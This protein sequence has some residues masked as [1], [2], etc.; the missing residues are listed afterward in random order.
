MRLRNVSHRAAVR[1]LAFKWIRIVYRCWKNRAI[2]DG[3]LHTQ[4]LQKR[5]SP[6]AIALVPPTREKALR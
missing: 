6:L 2:Y 3:A 1:A 4:A 5:G